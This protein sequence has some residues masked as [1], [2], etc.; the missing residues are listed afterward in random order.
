MK[1]LITG[2]TGKLGS[3]VMES[4]LHKVSAKDLAVSVRDTNKADKLKELG[5]DVRQ[6]DFDKA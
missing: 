3:K 2:A 5:V 1:I 6:G 4:L